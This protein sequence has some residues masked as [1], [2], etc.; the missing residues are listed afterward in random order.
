MKDAILFLCIS[1]LFFSSCKHADDPGATPALETGTPVSVIQIVAGPMSKTIDLQATASF[2][3]KTNINSNTS[4]YL[5][6]HSLHIGDRVFKGQL[7]FTVKTKESN[8]LGNSINALDSSFHFNGTVQILSNTNGFINSLNFQAGD[9]VQEGEA[10]ITINDASSFAFILNV[11]FEFKKYLPAN[12]VVQ[13]ELPD[14]EK[15]NGKI[16]S[17]MLQVDPVSQTQQYEIS[18]SSNKMIPENLIA[19]VKIVKEEKKFASMLPK[20][21]V[22]TNET[23]DNF[24]VMKMINDT[25]AVKVAVIKGI[26]SGNMVEIL[27]PQFEIAAQILT[28][29]NYGLA[30]T[31]KVIVESK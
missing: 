12:N 21:A 11:P 7:L 15:L 5:D 27:S 26:E 29:G 9:Y 2:L 18:V 30:D 20:S 25:T 17:A 14:G 8:A 6:Y 4:G 28:S 24:W 22:L 16:K 1:V 31:A 19:L 10:L 13:L 3:V 23:Q